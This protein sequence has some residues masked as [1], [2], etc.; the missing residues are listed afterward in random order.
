MYRAVQ[1]QGIR[2]WY[3]RLLVWSRQTHRYS[4]CDYR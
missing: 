3:F 4:T 2:A 1:L